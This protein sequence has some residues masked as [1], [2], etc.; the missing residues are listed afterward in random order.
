MLFAIFSAHPAGF[1]NTVWAGAKDSVQMVRA[2]Q[3][4][5]TPLSGTSRTCYIAAVTLIV[6]MLRGMSKRR[7]D[8]RDA[9]IQL[10]H[11]LIRTSVFNPWFSVRFGSDGLAQSFFCNKL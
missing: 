10:V 3:V 6:V 1:M 8:T 5:L 4:N 11:G 2:V 7:P 9:T